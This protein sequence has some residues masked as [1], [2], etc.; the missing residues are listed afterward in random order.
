MHLSI[1]KDNKKH[2]KSFIFISIMNIHHKL[3]SIKLLNIFCCH[4]KTRYKKFETIKGETD[5][6]FKRQIQ[7]L[8]LI[9]LLVIVINSLQFQFSAAL[10]INYYEKLDAFVK[11]VSQWYIYIIKPQNSHSLREWM[12][13]YRVKDKSKHVN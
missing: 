1:T 6:Y 10:C 7:M 3:W 12:F 5:E 13:E 4:F 2:I 8:V 9:Y 11:Q